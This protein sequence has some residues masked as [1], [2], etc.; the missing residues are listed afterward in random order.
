MAG[1]LVGQ[2]LAPI[3]WVL[4]G[5]CQDPASIALKNI[6]DM[7]CQVKKQVGV[8]PQDTQA[9]QASESPVV[10]PAPFRSGTAQARIPGKSDL[11]QYSHSQSNDDALEKMSNS[12][13]PS[14]A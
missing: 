12:N 3:C 13:Q 14:L 7:D 11:Q 9:Q 1:V 4:Y 8:V 2:N 6:Q 5:S 10:R